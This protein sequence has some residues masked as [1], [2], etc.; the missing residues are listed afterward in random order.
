[1]E[2]I[3]WFTRNRTGCVIEIHKSKECIESIIGYENK[4]QIVR[5]SSAC[6]RYEGPFPLYEKPKEHIKGA[7]LIEGNVHL[8]QKGEEMD[9]VRDRGASLLYSIG[10]K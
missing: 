5:G 8:V 1:M 9:W 7:V 10:N 2:P 3:A 6:Y 4:C